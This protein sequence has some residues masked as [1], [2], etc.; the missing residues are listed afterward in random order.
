MSS[1][2]IGRADH[3][4]SRDELRDLISGDPR[5][6][7]DDLE[8]LF[9]GEI[10][11]AEGIAID[12]DGTIWCGGEEGQ[13]YR[14]EP[15]SPCAVVAKIAGRPLGIALDASGVA[16]V[17]AEAGS[18]PGGVAAVWKVSPDGGATVL[19]TEVDGRGLV[20]PNHPAFLPDGTLLCTES[21]TW[22][23]DDGFVFSVGADGS[24]SII[25]RTCS[26]YPNGI[27]VSESGDRILVVESMLPGIRVLER[28]ADGS[29]EPSTVVVEL[30]GVIPDGVVLDD[31]GNMLI[32]CFAPDCVLVVDTV[33]NVEVVASD[34]RRF[35]LHSPT[36]VAFV[37]G[38]STVIAA[39]YG[40]RALT[41]F[42]HDRR[43]AAVHRP[44]HSATAWTPT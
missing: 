44:D 11:H 20:S 42:R 8:V 7:V 37:P 10:D 22:G 5:V 27:C 12:A 23:G 4:S 14:I 19:V 9:G 2:D 18:T 30:P 32:A 39:N 34:R 25:D 31:S 29:F 24:S 15:N 26:R 40:E 36:N 38:T 6:A 1:E 41:R 13:I 3:G 28:A 33:G 35:S 43:G 21:G 16:Y 17:A